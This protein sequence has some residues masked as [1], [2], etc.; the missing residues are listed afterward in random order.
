MK[1]LSINELI[2][3]HNSLIENFW[4][5]IGISNKWQLE[6]LLEHIQNNEYYPDTIGKATHLFFGIIEFHCFIDGNKRTA[7]AALDNFFILNNIVI[8]ELPVKL[9][10]LA[11]W[12]ASWIID[13]WS[14][15]NILLSILKSFW[16]YN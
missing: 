11:I 10:D 8:P 6:S 9:E 1:Y 5:M 15:K 16:Y 2:E 4:W 12:V 3:L 14:I 13:K 7:I